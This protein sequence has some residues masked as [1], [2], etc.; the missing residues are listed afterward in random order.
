MSVTVLGREFQEAG[1]EQ[2]SAR[3]ANAVL[4]SCSDNRVAV[5][6]RS[7]FRVTVCI[8]CLQ[9]VLKAVRLDATSKA[10]ANVTQTAIVP[11][12]LTL[13]PTSATVRIFTAL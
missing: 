1:A 6:E 10:E 12:C 5:V 4:A 3:L 8:F 7:L 9:S 11:T 2:R 13:T